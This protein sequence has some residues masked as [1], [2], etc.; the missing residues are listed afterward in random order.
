MN[1]LSRLRLRTKHANLLGLSALGLIASIAAGASLMHQRMP[2][3]RIDKQRAVMQS[4]MGFAQSLEKQV[5]AGRITREQALAR[6]RDD[7]H[8]TRFDT[9]TNYIL[10]Q[11]FDGVVVMHG[12]DPRGRG[13]QA[14]RKMRMADRAPT[15]RGIRCATRTKAS[16][17]ILPSNPERR[18]RHRS[19]P[20]SRGSAID[21]HP[22]C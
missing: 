5:T 19:C 17:R 6:F 11:T 2:Y 15:W 12:W 18:S 13:S 14:R 22:R 9:G 10:V 16:Y 8:T 4:A 21:R 20:T 1:I 7:L 3:D